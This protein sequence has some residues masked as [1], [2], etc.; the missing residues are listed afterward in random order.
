M[1]W[2]THLTLRKVHLVP[3]SP[4]METPASLQASTKDHVH[5][6]L[7]PKT[8]WHKFFLFLEDVDTIRTSFFEW[9]APVTA[10]AGL[11]VNTR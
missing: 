11:D 6:D 9:R 3:A 10:L 8:T 1:R 5:K 2:C 4:T 7:A